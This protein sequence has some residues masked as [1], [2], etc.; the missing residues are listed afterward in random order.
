MAQIYARHGIEFEAGKTG[1]EQSAFAG[2][3]ERNDRQVGFNKNLLRLIIKFDPFFDVELPGSELEQ[4]IVAR[5][6]P[7]GIIVAAVGGKKLHEIVRIRVVGAPSQ[8]KNMG[9]IVLQFF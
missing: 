9:R 6:L 1:I 7:T 8:T 5:I 2:P 4:L 3:E